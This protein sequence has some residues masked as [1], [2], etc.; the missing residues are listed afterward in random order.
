MNSGS[1]FTWSYTNPNL[2]NDLT[3]VAIATA[4]R[5]T[6]PTNAGVAGTYDIRNIMTHEAGHW[7]ML[8]DL[9]NNSDSELTM[10]GYGLTGEI[11]KDTLGYGDELGVESVYP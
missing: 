9:Y 8:G 6:D 4:G 5:Y 11:K 7:V 2:T 3:G 10:Y 1:G